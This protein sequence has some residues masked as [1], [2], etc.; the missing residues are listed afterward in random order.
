MFPVIVDFLWVAAFVFAVHRFSEVVAMFAP[1][2]VDDGLGDYN[3]DVPTDLVAVSLQE[4]EIWA[5]EEVMR[6]I[7]ER[8]EKLGDWNKVR[9]AMGVGRI[10]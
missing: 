6:V 1:Q 3:F 2:P 7:R 4:N 5:Q 10:D 9:T 8:Y